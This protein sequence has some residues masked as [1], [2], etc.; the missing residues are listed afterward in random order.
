M[1]QVELELREDFEF[2]CPVTGEQIVF[3]DDFIPSKAMIFNYVDLEG[4]FFAFANDWLKKVIIEFGLDI[5][6]EGWMDYEDFD[7]IMAAIINRVE[8]EN[9]VCFSI[10]TNGMACDP[11]S[12]TAYICID[13]N[14]NITK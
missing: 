11:M 13:M 6:D 7:K 9:Y 14:Y 2:F 4:G 1:Q 12:S 8:T 10:T 5:G 3:E